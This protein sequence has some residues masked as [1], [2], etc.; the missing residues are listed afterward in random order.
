M[1]SFGGGGERERE[2]GMLFFIELGSFE[3][4]KFKV[5]VEFN[6]LQS[7]KFSSYQNQ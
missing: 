1:F 3:N 4:K 6:V 5:I 2:R 7:P